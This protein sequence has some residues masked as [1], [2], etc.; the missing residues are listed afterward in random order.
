MD[1]NAVAESGC[2]SVAVYC[3]QLKCSCSGTQDDSDDK[4]G[5][6]VPSNLEPVIVN[7]RPL[8]GNRKEHLKQANM[9]NEDK[10]EEKTP[11]DIRLSDLKSGKSYTRCQLTIQQVET[12][13][14]DSSPIRLSEG[15]KCHREGKADD[16]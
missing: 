9:H 13:L 5:I 7:E 4:D 14:L 11:D 16:A 10:K 8:L 2:S 12:H 1:Y 15:N 3:S 6:P